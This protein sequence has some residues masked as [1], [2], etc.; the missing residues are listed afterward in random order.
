MTD[1]WGR[2]LVYNASDVR[3][4]YGLVASNGSCHSMVVDRMVP[5][6]AEEGISPD[7]GW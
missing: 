6:L 2:P 3:R 4:R 1:C 5:A 7:A